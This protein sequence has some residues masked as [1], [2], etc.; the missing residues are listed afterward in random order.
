VVLF[1]GPNYQG[2]AIN[3]MTDTA[4]L[5]ILSYNDVA[6]SLLLLPG[7]TG[8]VTVTEEFTG[9]T[10]PGPTERPITGPSHASPM[11]SSR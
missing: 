1:D 5:N 8:A 3:I 7:E 4:D 10:R 6:S 2:R 11:V 9:T